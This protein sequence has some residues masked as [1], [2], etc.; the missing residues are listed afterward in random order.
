M[1][2]QLRELLQAKG[3]DA[4][5]EWN[6]KKPTRSGSQWFVGK[7]WE[8]EG[9]DFY[10]ARFGDFKRDINEKWESGDAI[11]REQKQRARAEVEEALKIEK[12]EREREWQRVAA[13]AAAE[14][15]ND[16]PDIDTPY[17]AKKGVK[18]FGCRAR[19]GEVG[20][21]I[22]IIPLRDTS[23]T[24]WNLQR[25]YNKKF[26]HGD[27]F[28]IEG[29][30][31]IGLFH[32]LSDLPSPANFSG[33]IFIA[34]GY[35][36]GASIRMA[37][38][39]ALVVIAFNANNL[40]HVGVELKKKYKQAEFIVCADNDAYTVIQG[41]PK[42]V[43][44]EKGR[45]TAGTIQGEIRW[46]IFKYPQKGLTDFN[47]LHQAEGLETVADQIL[48]P[49]KYVK[50]I[51]PMCLTLSKNG[52]IQTPTEKEVCDYVL[53]H[54]GDNILRFDKSLFTYTGTHW[55]ELD[56]MAEDMVKQ[57]IQV[58]ANGEL[59]YR[60][61]ENYFKYIK[62]HAPQT[63]PGVDLFQPNPFAANFKNGTLHL[64]KNGDKKYHLKFRPHDRTDYLTSVLP[65]D[66]PDLSQPLPP[67]PQFDAMVE[68]LWAGNSDKETIKKLAYE[69]IGGC[70]IP[71]FPS[72]TLFYGP[73][74][75]GKSTFIKL[76]VKLVSKENV[77]N[78]QPSDF[79]GFN[80]E[81]MVGKLV[82]FDTDIDTQKPFS[83]SEVKKIIDRNPRRI[84]RKGRTDITGYLPAMH[85]FASNAL[86]K[87]LDGNSKAY[88]HRL[89]I[90]HTFSFQ[91]D[92]DVR[93]DFEQ[94]ILDEELPAIIARGLEGL[95]R[96]AEQN[97]KYTSLA[98]SAE[99][100]RQFEAP[101]DIVGQFLEDI[102]E[103]EVRDQNNI[104]QCGTEC[105][106]ER[107]NLW[108]VFQAWQEDSLTPRDHLSKFAFFQGLYKRG[109]SVKTKDGIRLFSGI[110]IVVKSD[111][112]T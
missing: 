52:K 100:V 54:Y 20:D 65:F 75:S 26:E 47:D 10:F 33:Q 109:F 18:N 43:G 6:T 99:L 70:L 90:I 60:E 46:P 25:I 14:F 22:T 34:E 53:K 62:V 69:L 36:T 81:T 86:P 61:L 64:Y 1:L 88:E 16:I 11:T 84:R 30:R 51:Q 95:K 68:R 107:K 49:E 66:C 37:L 106:I 103:G 59:G 41:K 72:I 15:A 24:I 93:Y 105:Q 111:A 44:L 76:L 39:D 13:T 67:A 4:P 87:T 42:N 74:R 110:G 80:M 97:G 35:A 56:A 38:P 45:L 12:E 96:L 79:H 89:T 73:P 78:V 8:L 77:S 28:F 83:D 102:K 17:L 7:K 48:H 40:Y 91:P 104:L 94:E 85:L 32:S 3:I 63:P 55:V 2:E 101:S 98:S 29:G 82:N 9:K 31:I 57:K 112:V 58:A 21:F 92:K 50:G 19:K 71:A 27:K 108:S 5:I 23:G